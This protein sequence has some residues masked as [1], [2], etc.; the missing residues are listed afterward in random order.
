LRS[1]AH[2]AMLARQQRQQRRHQ[3]MSKKSKESP[4]SHS[5]EVGPPHEQGTGNA[6]AHAGPGDR[7]SGKI[8]E[9]EFER[10]LTELK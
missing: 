10:K 7:K 4:A 1:A 2:S 6:P 8:S 3:I 5:A 9:E